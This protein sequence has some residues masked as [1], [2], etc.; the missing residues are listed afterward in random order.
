MYVDSRIYV[1]MAKQLGKYNIRE[2]TNTPERICPKTTSTSKCSGKAPKTSVNNLSAMEVNSVFPEYTQVKEA[3]TSDKVSLS[4]DMIMSPPKLNR[5]NINIYVLIS[6]AKASKIAINSDTERKIEKFSKM[7]G[8]DLDHEHDN[9]IIDF[10][11]KYEKL[12][13]RVKSDKNVRFDDN[14]QRITDG[15]KKLVDSTYEVKE[16]EKEKSNKETYKTVVIEIK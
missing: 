9:Y 6:Q 11:E 8:L 13:A 12:N 4:M 3:I 2:D 1:R 5:E 7:I 14:I 16:D 10:K 15:S